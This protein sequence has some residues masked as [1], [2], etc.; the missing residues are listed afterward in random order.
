MKMLQKVEARII[1]IRLVTQGVFPKY[2]YGKQSG[3]FKTKIYSSEQMVTGTFPA[4]F[5]SDGI[6]PYNFSTPGLF[7]A[8]LFPIRSFPLR[9]F[10][11]RYFAILF[12]FRQFF[13]RCF[14]NK[15]INLWRFPEG[16]C[17]E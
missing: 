7:P 16:W 5:F 1:V 13:H 4:G 15:E 2:T 3:Q 8:N 6:L 17:N 11:T 10:P 12:F 9:F 14:L